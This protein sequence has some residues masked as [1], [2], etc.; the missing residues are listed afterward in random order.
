MVRL[1]RHTRGPLIDWQLIPERHHTAEPIGARELVG[2][3]PGDRVVITLAQILGQGRDI[4]RMDEHQL[5]RV[6]SQLDEAVRTVEFLA[7][8][9]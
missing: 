4:D 5:G 8:K 9:P 2:T 3:A 6:W 1:M 7:I